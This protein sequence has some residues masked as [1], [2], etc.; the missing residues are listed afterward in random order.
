VQIKRLTPKYVSELVHLES[1][2]WQV[3][4]IVKG[5]NIRMASRSQLKNLRH[6][7]TTVVMDS[8]KNAHTARSSYVIADK[9]EVHEISQRPGAKAV[10]K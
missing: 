5:R 4:N 9:D 8:V 1:T 6:I 7:F 3:I 10:N 2:E